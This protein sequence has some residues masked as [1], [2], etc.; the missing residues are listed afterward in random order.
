M[1]HPTL[2]NDLYKSLNIGRNGRPSLVWPFRPTVFR[3][4]TAPW[5]DITTTLTNASIEPLFTSLVSCNTSFSRSTRR[6]RGW[7]SWA[8]TFKSPCASSGP[9]R[10]HDSS[11][12]PNYFELLIFTWLELVFP[13]R[14]W[15]K[16]IKLNL[17]KKFLPK[18]FQAEVLKK[19]YLWFD[20]NLN[21]SFVWIIWIE[22]FI[23]DFKSQKRP[24]LD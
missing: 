13:A 9:A 8:S 7:K 3:M 2:E 17:A 6:N 1:V 18:Y 16:C 14:I 11:S 15:S 23:L 4:Y 24:Q 19:S 5:L 22:L 12:W 10:S 21:V 20:R